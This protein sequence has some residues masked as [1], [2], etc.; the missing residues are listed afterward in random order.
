[1]G[2]TKRNKKKEKS[3]TKRNKIIKK[4]KRVKFGNTYRCVPANEK[5]KNNGK[6][7]TI[8]GEIMVITKESTTYDI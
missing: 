2:K 5:N 8:D 3:K 7:I 4:Q 6:I 1:M